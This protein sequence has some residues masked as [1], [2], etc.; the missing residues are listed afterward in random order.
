M[1]I[2]HRFLK[3]FRDELRPLLSKTSY[4][5]DANTSRVCNFYSK[6]KSSPYTPISAKGP[7]II[8]R[9]NN[10]VYDVGGYGMLGFGHNPDWLLRTMAKPHVMANVMT[11]SFEQE[12]VTEFLGNITPYDK[13]A[14][15]NSGSEGIEFAMRYIDKINGLRMRNNDQMDVYINLKSGFHGRTFGAASISNSCIES[16][17]QTPTLGKAT[18]NTLS[19]RINDKFDFNNAFFAAEKDSG[20]NIAGVFME[21]VMGEGNPGEAMDP[22]YYNF[23]RNITN[24]YDIP[25][26]IDSV[27]AGLRTNGCLSITEYPGFELFQ[28]PDFEIFSKAISG[29]HYPLSIV[30]VADKFRDVDIK[31]IYGNSMCANPKAL[32]ICY[33]VLD[34]FYGNNY[35]NKIHSKAFEFRKMLFRI[36]HKYPNIIKRINGKGLLI[37]MA[38]DKSIPVSGENSLEYKCRLEGL[39][40]IH[41]GDN[42]LRFTPYFDITME[43]IELV[44]NILEKVIRREYQLKT[45]YYIN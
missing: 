43:E 24:Y 19:V 2:S 28:S 15:L 31:G 17:R 10:I 32:D 45:T 33:A 41:G 42:A 22:D 13:F 20:I 23:V 27:Q 3:S 4:I 7:W 35:R 14:F 16:Y 34:R 11:P 30:A 18:N 39:N 12:R 38:I 9:E 5:K 36:M 25:L 29:G 26:V 44:G 37:S 1:N 40:V 8:T 6:Y 21:P